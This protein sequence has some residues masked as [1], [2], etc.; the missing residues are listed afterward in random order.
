MFDHRQIR[1]APG[2]LRLGDEAWWSGG[3]CTLTVRYSNVVAQCE[4]REPSRDCRPQV[5][6]LARAFAQ[7]H[8]T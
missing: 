4:E 5:E 1:K 7:Q 8:F 2:T 3:D 6:R